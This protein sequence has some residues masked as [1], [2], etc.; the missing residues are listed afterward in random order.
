ML[1]SGTIFYFTFPHFLKCV[2]NVDYD[3]NRF[4]VSSYRGKEWDY[5][6]KF[7]WAF[8]LSKPYE[9]ADT[10]IVMFKGGRPIPLQIFHHVGAVLDMWL[11][12]KNKN[13]AAWIFVI[14]NSLIHTLMY[15][16]YSLTTLGFK[17]KWKILMTMMQITQFIVGTTIGYMYLST[18]GGQTPAQ[19]AV[20]SIT[21]SYV[22]VKI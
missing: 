13:P 16:Y 9:F 15:A 21:L 4:I 22:Y 20:L 11:I 5:F 10:W 8:Y 14:F 19:S 12:V 17:P 2:E 6:E 7:V 18:E 3:L 1:F